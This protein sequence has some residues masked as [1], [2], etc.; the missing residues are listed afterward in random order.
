MQSYILY[1]IVVLI[2]AFLIMLTVKAIARGIEAKNIKK[3]DKL[4]K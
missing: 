4:K 1:F 3:K 2:F